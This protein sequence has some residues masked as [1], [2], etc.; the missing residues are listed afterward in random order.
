MRTTINIQKKLFL[1]LENASETLNISKNEIVDLLLRKIIAANSFKSKAFETVRY[2]ERDPEKNWHQLHV[3]FSPRLYETG[4]DS[5]K[6][7]KYTVSYVVSFAIIN[8]LDELINKIIKLN[9][10]VEKVDNY[11]LDYIFVAKDFN[12]F[13]GFVIIWGVP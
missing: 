11:P 3:T 1:K 5:R 13:Q 12:N 4:L 2:Q 6:F 9:Y 8:Y 10:N 7:F